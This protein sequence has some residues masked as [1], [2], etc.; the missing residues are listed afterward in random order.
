MPRRRKP[1]APPSLADLPAGTRVVGYLRHSPG[2]AQRIDSQVQA[3]DVYIAAHAWRLCHPYWID[4]FR[5]GSTDKREE[6]Q[7]FLE[8]ARAEP[9][10][11]DVVL[12]WS[13]SRFARSLVLSQFYLA[14][15]RMRGFRVVSLS[16]DIP[17]GDFA[18]ILESLVHWKNEQFLRDL[19]KDVKRGLRNVVTQ[20]ITLPDGTVK[21]GFSGGGFPP[22]GYRS[23]RVQTGTKRNGE[24][25]FNAYWELDPLW[26]ERAQ[27]AWSMK[28]EGHSHADIYVATGLFRHF[29]SYGEMF[30][31]RQYTG[32]RLNGDVAVPSA[33]PAYVDEATFAQIQLTLPQRGNSMDERRHASPFLLSGLAFCGYCDTAL[34]YY[35]DPR[36]QDA[37]QVRCPNRT[38]T[39][40]RAL[41]GGRACELRSLSR[42]RLEEGVITALQNEILQPDRMAALLEVVNQQLGE[43]EEKASGRR[44]AIIAELAALERRIERLLDELEASARGEES[45]RLRSRLAERE[46]QRKELVEELDA[47]D[48]GQAA[49]SVR[50]LSPAALAVLL[51][52]LRQLLSDLDAAERR[53]VLVG[54]VARVTLYND[55][56]DLAY[57]L[58]L[59]G[60]LLVQSQVPPRGRQAAPA[61]DLNRLL[62]TCPV[63]YPRGYTVA[64]LRPC[65]VCGEPLT[66]RQLRRGAVHCSR[67][68]AQASPSK[69]KRMQELQAKLALG[70]DDRGRFASSR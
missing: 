54:L 17:E 29:S 28:A 44:A 48:R 63:P 41:R 68:C 19:S 18:I 3:L 58:P 4:E 65:A 26:Q 66:L 13:F 33:H 20:Q 24:P 60:Q 70:H 5:E 35:P 57:R 56:A 2:D 55:R 51:A 50:R 6:F 34:N 15:L 36:Q 11:A 40:L 62:L 38:H 52:D 30:R 59:N 39:R 7:A 23:V 32:C 64:A 46:G 12:I 25:R 14:D 21:T 45:A 16:D 47:L 22:R 53:T 10:P 37:G 42:R 43:Q 49:R 1:A 8:W 67:A 69:V 27:R 61:E 9:R 31:N